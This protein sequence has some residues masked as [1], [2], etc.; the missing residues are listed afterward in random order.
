MRERRPQQMIFHTW[1]V[2]QLQEQVLDQMGFD[3]F[4]KPFP[5]GIQLHLNIN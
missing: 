2:L 5:H 1:K 3:Q 4:K